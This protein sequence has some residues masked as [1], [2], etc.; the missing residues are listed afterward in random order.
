MKKVLLV[1]QG[2]HFPDSALDFIRR[3]NDQSPLM[4]TGL[5]L[6]EIVPIKN[7]AAYSAASAGNLKDPFV[8]AN[9]RKF[10]EKCSSCDIAHRLHLG[11][12]DL[13]LPQVIEESMFADLLIASDAAFF[14]EGNETSEEGL[15]HAMHDVSCPVL[16]I[17][18][19]Y[20]YPQQI[21]LAYDGSASAMYAIKQFAYLFPELCRL[22]ITVVY[23][24]EAHNTA[25][26]H[27]D[28]A[29]EW[30]DVHFPNNKFVSLNYKAKQLFSSETNARSVLVVAGSFGRS[31]ISQWLQPSFAAELFAQRG[32]ILF[33]AHKT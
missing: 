33:T 7:W 6:P 24:N 27:Q 23:E 31:G 5:L 10:E 29:S 22:E 14:T 17:P 25:I 12:T 1:M 16:V 19:N 11:T 28:Y 32:L 8:A 30:M 26:P 20:R 18:E 15:L 3:L 9:T 4:V 21:M 2:D 13:A